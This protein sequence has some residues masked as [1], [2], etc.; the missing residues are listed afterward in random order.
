MTDPA[1]DMNVAIRGAAD[2]GDRA[3]L[4]AEARK[5]RRRAQEAE[6]RVRDAEAELARLRGDAAAGADAAGDRRR[7]L[8]EERLAEALQ[9]PARLLACPDPR[10][11]AALIDRDGIEWDED[12]RPEPVSVRGALA[13]AMRA[14]PSLR[15]STGTADAG[16]GGG[17]SPAPVDMNAAI[18]GQADWLA[19]TAQERARE[20]ADWTMPPPG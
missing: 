7:E 12:G 16:A 14:F 11:A 9:A 2:A 6:A 4:V 20:R 19:A 17:E 18:R 5:L 13:A 8:C 15:V 3:R 1:P 10:M